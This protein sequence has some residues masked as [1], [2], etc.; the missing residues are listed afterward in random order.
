MYANPLL[1]YR[2]GAWILASGATSTLL[3]WE[4]REKL[5]FKG[6]GGGYRE[7]TQ[8]EKIQRMK[9]KGAPLIMSRGSKTPLLEHH[10]YSSFE[11]LLLLLFN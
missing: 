5:D 7:A 3:L 9:E 4:G 6:L 10:Y 2:Q 1:M 8:Q 11:A